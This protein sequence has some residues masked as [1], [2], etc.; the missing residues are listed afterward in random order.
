MKTSRSFGFSLVLHALIISVAVL[1]F[2]IV[3]EK[4]EEVVLELSLSAPSEEPQPMAKNQIS[5]SVTTAMQNVK[6]LNTPEPVVKAVT[7]P[8][9]EAIVSESKVQKEPVAVTNSA[10]VQQTAS[11]ATNKLPEPSA[12]PAPP[13]V[14]VEEQYLDNHLSAIRDVLVKYRKYPN[15]AVRQKQEGDVRVSFRLKANGE[16]EDITIISSSGYTILDDDAKALIEKTSLY[17]PRP[18][19][20]IRITVPLRYSLKTA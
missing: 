9:K 17:F 15:Q 3:P 10:V 11:T 20:S 16:V 13:T 6:S 19:K 14:N 18:P 4:D 5:P 2:S 8:I 7:E 1:F 12:P